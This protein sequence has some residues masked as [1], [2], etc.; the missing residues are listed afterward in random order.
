MTGIELRIS[1]IVSDH[2]TNCT[3]T[4]V[5]QGYFYRTRLF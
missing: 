5:K 3:Q 4:T 1:I 2:S